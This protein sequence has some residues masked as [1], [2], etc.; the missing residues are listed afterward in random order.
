MATLTFPQRISLPITERPPLSQASGNAIQLL[1]FFFLIR[2]LKL[3]SKCK[4]TKSSRGGNRHSSTH[5]Y[6]TMCGMDMKNIVSSVLLQIR[7]WVTPYFTLVM[8]SSSC[9]YPLY[10]E[11]KLILLCSYMEYFALSLISL[12]EISLFF[13]RT[14]WKGFTC[15][16]SQEA[17]KQVC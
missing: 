1:D 12:S 9:S 6:L 11:S 8:S 16:C 10:V 2:S 17:S 4:K 5:P 13:S 3:H 14:F 7:L 15:E